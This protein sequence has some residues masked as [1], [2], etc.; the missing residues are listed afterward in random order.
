MKNFDSSIIRIGIDLGTTNSEIAVNQGTKIEI[1]NNP[2]GNSFYTPSVFGVNSKGNVVIGAKAYEQLFTKATKSEMGNYVAEIKR[3]M[4]TQETVTI[5]GKKYSPEEISA[6]ILKSLKNDALRRYPELSTIAAVITVPA[7][8][9]TVQN[10]ATKKAGLLAGFDHVVLIQEPIAAAI[11]YGFK[12]QK[13]STW[14]VFDFGGGTF[15]VALVNA[16]DGVLTVLEH[17]GDNFLG[18]KDIDLGIVNDIIVPE[19]QKRFD[20]PDL[21][22]KNYPEIFSRLKAIAEQAKIALSSSATAEVEIND[23]DLNDR[24]GS[25]VEFYFELTRKQ[26]DSIIAPIVEKTIKLC[27][28]TIALSQIK[29]DT[30]SKVVFVGGPTQI[31]YLRNQVKKRLNI[32]IDTSVNPFTVVAEGAA[33]YASSQRIPQHILDSRRENVSKEEIKVTLNYEPMTSDQEQLITGKID[34]LKSD[35]YFIKISSEN[36]DFYHSEKIRI[37]DGSFFLTVPLELSKMNHFWIYL[38]DEKGNNLKVYPESFSITQGLS[39]SGAPIAQA[40]GVIYSMPS[41]QAA[42][43]WADA[44]EVYFKRNSIV[45]LKETRDF[46]TIKDAQKGE[47]NVI[48][49]IVYE[50]DSLNPDEVNHITRISLPEKDKTL[51][52]NLP[53][54]T[55]LEITLQVN[56]ARELFVEIYIPTLDYVYDARVD[57]AKAVKSKKSMQEEVNKIQKGINEIDNR[58][59]RKEKEEIQEQFENINQLIDQGDADS[60]LKAEKEMKDLNAKVTSMKQKTNFDKV[61]DVYKQKLNETKEVISEVKNEEKK[62]EFLEYLSAVEKQS[63]IFVSEKNASQLLRSNEL[64]DQ[65]ASNALREGPQFWVNAFQYLNS[66]SHLF[67]NQSEANRL[68]KKAESAIDDNDLEGL[69]DCI[70]QLIEMLPKKAQENMPSNIS[71]ITK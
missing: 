28:K 37:V 64:L 67:A 63:E 41:V 54:G 12:E 51:P 3:L 56:E 33:I 66:R 2:S 5:R 40:I 59:D 27:E 46:K 65:I 62:K 21:N 16:K 7:H 52:F 13:D 30:I 9:D 48:P 11:A 45:P 17:Q 50:G 10:E 69:K 38:I 31:P 70:S 53:K 55:T 68:L 43:G 23:L 25:A 18:G 61:F 34:S 44:C 60:A 57:L 42:G 26:L 32:D 6:E 58:L 39:L 14:L 8:F 36:S 49:I 35:R 1:I 15:D 4:G 20:L 29:K 24:K 71:G 19:I 47:F 22:R